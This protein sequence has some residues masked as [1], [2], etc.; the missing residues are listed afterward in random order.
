[1]LAAIGYT[2]WEQ[3]LA[4]ERA[5]AELASHRSHGRRSVAVLGFKNL[6]GRSDTAWLST[7]LSEMLSTELTA[8]G[9]L[10]TIP[11]ESVAQTKISLSLPEADSLSRETLGRVYKNLG[12]DFVVL[13]SFLDMGNPGYGG[14]CRLDLRVQDAA[15]GETMASLA[16]NGSETE[17]P[18]LVRRT[19]A[20]LRERLG[21]CTGSRLLKL[22]VCGR[23]FLA[24]QKPRD[25]TRSSGKTPRLRCAGSTRSTA[26]ALPR[27]LAMQ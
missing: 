27:I 5:R 16:E 22:P 24:M 17:L 26:K 15:L 3:R 7:A 10:R 1:M 25:C 8:G 12:S 4:T 9:K 11:G 20:A 14:L 13:G 23:L 21:I 18:D 6:S 19:G 2:V